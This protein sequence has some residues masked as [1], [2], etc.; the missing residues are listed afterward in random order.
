MTNEDYQKIFHEIKNYITFINSSLQL[1]EKMHPEIKD[2]P[3]WAN[4]MQELS[5]LKK[6]LIEL[7]SAR[8]C[9]DLTKINTSPDDFLSELEEAC[10]AMFHS[11]DFCLSISKSP[12]LPMCRID[13]EQLKRALFNIIKN[14]YE[15]MAG[16]GT[17][18]LN[19][20]EKDSCLCLDVIDSGGGIDP[21]ILPELF[22][23]F[24]TTKQGG[25]GLGLLIAKQAIEA[26]NGSLTVDSRPQD[27]CT[28]S[29]SVPLLD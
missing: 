26:H 27:G 20:Y 18:R 25:T 24:K 2:Y 16:K 10:F 19:A 28:F 12:S 22:T 4:S 14:A 13:P 15:A 1:V 11:K 17:I 5:S 8:S 3:Y 21:E 29:I 9:N 6:M 23:P 7:G